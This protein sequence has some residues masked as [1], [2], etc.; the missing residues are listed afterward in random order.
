MEGITPEIKELL[1]LIQKKNKIVAMVAPSFLVD[2][3]YPQFVG[4]LRRMGFKH[5]VEVSAGAARTNRQ[6]HALLKLHPERRY[7]T[8]PC[9]SIV[10]LIRNKYPNLIP[11]LTPIDSP[12]TATAKIVA[13]EYPDCKKVYIGPCLVKKMEAKED[14]PE[15]DILVLTYKEIAKVFEIKKISP[16]SRDRHSYFD[17]TGS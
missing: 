1:N 7:I 6:L 11:F 9:P 14:H 4:M 15:L 3:S 13:K 2:F 10:R 17:I 5:V 8:N 12:M 16:E